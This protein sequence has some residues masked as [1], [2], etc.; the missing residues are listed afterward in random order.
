MAPSSGVSLSLVQEAQRIQDQR[1]RSFFD[2]NCAWQ[3]GPL[4][5]P[6]TAHPW[7]TSST[8]WILDGAETEWS[9]YSRF[10]AR[11][12]FR[13]LT[14]ENARLEV[15]MRLMRESLSDAA[16]QELYSPPSWR[17]FTATLRDASLGSATGDLVALERMHPQAT[18]FALRHAHH[19]VGEAWT[20]AAQ[21]VL[22]QHLVH[23]RKRT[24]EPPRSGAAYL[25][26]LQDAVSAVELFKRHTHAA[27]AR[28]A[29]RAI[30]HIDAAS[31]VLQAANAVASQPA[32]AAD[33]EAAFLDCCLELF[34]KLNESNVM[35]RLLL[36]DLT[37]ETPDVRSLHRMRPPMDSTPAAPILSPPTQA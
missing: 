9:P 31:Y 7:L 34:V 18:L 1:K 35:E 19:L 6:I 16:D 10:A 17:R 3:D 25:A 28:Y 14:N 23:A 4:R 8:N 33:K 30:A 37:L 2:R 27:R 29:E 22:E 21:A 24:F 32:G 20:L 13:M 5:G 26:R 15:R 12:D 36:G 11:C